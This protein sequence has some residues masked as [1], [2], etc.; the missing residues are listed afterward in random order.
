MVANGFARAREFQTSRVAARWVEALWQTVPVSTSGHGYRLAARVRGY[1]AVA[2][3]A[4][5]WLRGLPPTQPART[6][7]NQ[8]DT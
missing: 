7:P 2:R 6:T 8:L 3:Q 1:R 5:R 4:R